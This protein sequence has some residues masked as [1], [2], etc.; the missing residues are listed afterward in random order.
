[1]RPVE[2]DREE[3]R[4]VGL[5]QTPQLL[6]RHLRLRPVVVQVVFAFHRLRGRRLQVP[7]PVLIDVPGFLASPDDGGLPGFLDRHVVRVPIHGIGVEGIPVDV[8]LRLTPGERVRDHVVVDL[9]DGHGVVPVPL[10]VLRQRHDVGDGLPEIGLQ[11]PHT[12]GVGAKAGHHA[13]ARRI[14][15]RLLNVS[16]KER[17]PSFSETVHV[18]RADVR[19]SVRPE[20]G[21][22]VVDGYE[23]HVGPGR[24]GHRFGLPTRLQTRDG[25][26]RQER[27]AGPYQAV[28]T[29]HLQMTGC[30]S[31]PRVT[32]RTGP[33]G[34]GRAEPVHPRS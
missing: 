33:P 5:R 19:V 6:D 30:R 10:E 28:L 7:L 8:E 31:S 16:L 25:Q 1:M 32:P 4:L 24:L 29:L 20:F 12:Q 13:G 2:A 26:E 23:Q 11:I 14:A 21:P 27:E 22:Q 9:P 18:R 34:R 17:D 3:E 15:H